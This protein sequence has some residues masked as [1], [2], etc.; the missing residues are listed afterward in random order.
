MN[1]QFNLQMFADT[2]VPMNLIEKAWSKQLWKEAEKDN[3]FAKF[4][5]TGSDAIIQIKTELKKE[6]GDQITVPL[7]MRLV[8]EGVTGDNMLEGNE[9]ALQFYDCQVKV[10]QI[11]HA[12]RLKGRM[13]EQKTSLN[14]RSAAKDSL[15]TWM[16]EKQEKM[17]VDVLTATPTAEHTVYANGRT[18]ESE[19]TA[20]DVFTADMISIAARKAKTLEPKIRRVRVEGKEYYVMLIDN[21]QARDL[22][23]DEKWLEA[24]KHAAAR[25]KDNP[26][27]TGA[28]GVYDG[29][30]VHEYENLIRT[31]TGASSAK[32][33]HALLLGAQAGIKGVAQEASWKEDT[34]DYGNKV[35]VATGAILGFAKSKFNG[36]DF[37]CVQVIT[38]SIDD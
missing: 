30:V 1:T 5:G 8:G 9:E 10:D 26:I 35:G 19:V 11:R 37:A 18:A 23:N 12:V 7:L 22:K 16:V 6:A 24:Q 17:I 31:N 36:K 32:V 27:F 33:G 2:E 28:L 25:G 29:V 14:L 38:S 20:A 15:K 13:E 3:F 4:T 21:Y 34:F